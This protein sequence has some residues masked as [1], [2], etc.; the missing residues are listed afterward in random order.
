M[1]TNYAVKSISLTI[2]TFVT[3]LLCLFGLATVLPQSFATPRSPLPPLPHVT[4]TLFHTRFDEAYWRE[5]Q[6]AS[7]VMMD[8]WTLV[9]SFSGYALQRVG[10]SVTPFVIPALNASNQ[11]AVAADKGALA[12]WFKPSWS[13][14]SGSSG[15]AKLAELVAVGRDDAVSSWALQIN[16]EQTAMILTGLNGSEI[17]LKSEIRLMPDVWYWVVLNYGET[18]ELW[19]DGVLQAEGKGTQALPPKL[20]ALVVGSNLIGTETAGGEFEDVSLFSHAL[21]ERQMVLYHRAMKAR[22]LLGAISVEEEVAL[23]EQRAKRQAELVAL[24]DEGGT[25]QMRFASSGVS[26]NCVT[27]GPV[28][29]TN[30][31]C[32]FTTNNGWTVGFDIVGGTNGFPY[33]VFSTTNLV[34]N[35]ITNSVWKWEDTG[36]TCNSYTFTNQHTN[37]TFFILGTPQ[38]SDGDGLPDA[39]EKLVSRTSPLLR[40]T[41]NDGIEDGD[42]LSPNGIPWRLERVRQTEVVVYAMLPNATEGG[43]CGQFRV[44]LPSPAPPGGV[45]VQYRLGGSAIYPDEFTVSPAANSLTIAAGGTLGNITICA[46]NN[47]SYEDLDRYVEITLTNANGYVVNGIPAQVNLTDNDPPGVRVFALPPWVREPSSTYGTNTASF[48]FIRDGAAINGAT[49]NFVITGTAT[50]GVDYDLL[51]SSIF[52]PAGVRTYQLNVN[53]R[54]DVEEEPDE[55]IIL[56]MNNAAGYQLDPQNSSATIVIASNGLPAVPTVQVTATDDDAR[57]AGLNPGQFTFT[58]TGSTAQPLRVFYRVSG[59]AQMASTN[60]SRD[61]VGLPGVVDFAIGA[62]NAVV[63]VTPYDDNISETTETVVV[64]LA[65]GEYKIGT[66]HTATVYIDDDEPSGWTTQIVRHGIYDASLIRQRAATVRITRYGSAL[67]STTLAWTL[68]NTT[69]ANKISSTTATGNVLGN[70]ITWGPHQSVAVVN[71]Q[72]AWDLYLQSTMI[73]TLTLSNALGQQ[74]LSVLYHPASRLVSVESATPPAS[75]V[76]EGTTSAGALIF[77]RPY[78]DT[79]AFTVYL[80]TSGS[81]VY[82]TNY[83]NQTS[84]PL[85]VTFPASQ[86]A[87]SVNVQAYANS[88]TNGWKTGVV[89]FDPAYAGVQL[90]D[91]PKERAFIRIQDAQITNPVFDTDMDEDGLPDGFE[92]SNQPTLDPTVSNDPYV[93]LDGDGLGLFEEMQLGTNPNVPDAQPLFPSEEDSDYITLTL[94]L[95]AIGKMSYAANCAVCHEVGVRVGG[96]MRTSPRVSWEVT[97]NTVNQLIRFLRGTNYAANLICNPYSKVLPSAQTNGLTPVY[98]AKYTAMFLTQSNTPYPFLT[99]TNQ[100]FGTSRTIVLEALGKTATLF[101]PEMIIATDVDG[102]G[103]VDFTNRTDRTS[104]NAPFQFWI[105]DDA[106][107][108][109]DDAAE[110]RDPTAN[111]INSATAGIDN[112][113]DLED[114]ARMQFRIDALPGN[115]LTNAG[116]Q[117]RIYLTNLVGSPSIRLFPATEVNG[118]IGYL[119]NTTTGAAQTN[120]TA[121]GVLSSSSPITLSNT[122]WQVNAANRFTLPMIFEGVTTGRCV[123]VF[124]LASNTGPALVTSRPFYLDLKPVTSLYEHWTVGDN[125]TNEWN[126]IPTIATR[127]ADSAVFGIPTTTVERDYILLVHGWRMKPWERRSFAST[128]FK[129]LWHSGYKGR[130]GLFSWPTDYTETDILSAVTD[131]RNYDRSERRA[132]WSGWGL[133]WLL[134]NLDQI[135]S[136]QVRLVS[137]SMGGIVSSEALRIRGNSR[138]NSGPLVHSYV[139][140]QAASVANA[141]D[142]NGPEQTNLR[143]VPNIFSSFPRYGTNAPYFKNMKRAVG[144]DPQTQLTR[145][146]NFHNFQ[147]YA[148]TGTLVWPLNQDVKPLINQRTY[149]YDTKEWIGYPFEKTYRVPEDS[150]VLF[151]YLAQ[152]WSP[153]LGASVYGSFRTGV[154]MGNDQNLNASPIGFTSAR[155]DHSA[156]FNGTIQRRLIYW[157]TLRQRTGL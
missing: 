126:Q 70:Q 10:K 63:A 15:N 6:R 36:Y 22:S 58:R 30:V 8:S 82:G 147:D 90:A 18:T 14:M 145:T 48:Y 151:G 152:S 96:Q 1:K 87:V 34:G 100:M 136:G 49:V 46:V 116:L 12:F 53:L 19:I 44:L 88:Q 27:N 9:E 69:L 89:K 139:P 119:T 75:V 76:N 125:T 7:L 131:A 144:I 149:Y 5:R 51:P 57:E 66:N 112:L 25:A 80:T 121:L 124:G 56:T 105:N 32:Y 2:P 122:I 153:A 115:F 137:H 47:S 154:E 101:A 127:T 138:R 120:A 104:A 81:A 143:D 26:V 74:A 146:W 73:P 78:A 77:R 59:T 33:D 55:T 134:L 103:L 50:N 99:D 24:A 133:N 91:A 83:T 41:D 43:A 54:A 128:G 135:Y 35:H 42:E 140:S 123:I 23:A 95:G 117:T 3:R 118:G 111:P 31:I 107:F 141:Y 60:T 61:F 13:S 110:D 79:N 71:Y 109:N 21:K 16:P 92:I 132:W 130:Y 98:S 113:R 155:S 150:Y 156:Q 28:Y 84:Q 142:A 39:Y 64:V 106:D 11:L 29:M 62:A 72:T 67:T 65:V 68:T 52:F 157:Q 20:S 17:L 129:R 97:D 114:F 148:L 85:Q 86:T 94:R 45:T 38:D 4:T 40:D 93:D 37:Q 102:N 108:G